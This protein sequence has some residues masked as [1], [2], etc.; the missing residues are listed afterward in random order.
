MIE[1]H[2]TFQIIPGKEEAFE[3]LFRDEYR[4]AMAAAPGFI[5]AELLRAQ[6]DPNQYQMVIR[7][8]TKE[9]AA[10]WRASTPH[11]ML[12]PKLKMLYEK[13]RLE[14]YEVVL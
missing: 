4:P 7:F 13:S 11:E 6:D 5:K 8:A 12:R 3:Q 2:V 14:V 1:R 10:G 9:Q